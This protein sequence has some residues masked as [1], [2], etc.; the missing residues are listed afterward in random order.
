MKFRL[1]DQ[2]KVLHA[3]T[4]FCEDRI[5]IFG[6]SHTNRRKLWLRKTKGISSNSNI[7]LLKLLLNYFW[8]IFDVLSKFHQSAMNISGSCHIKFT[9]NW[10]KI[11]NLKFYF[12]YFIN[13]VSS[14]KFSSLL[15]YS[16]LHIS[17]YFH[18]NWTNI[19][20]TCHT[21]VPN[22]EFNNLEQNLQ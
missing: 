13:R 17:W 15:F 9:K 21:K 20:G 18:L 8:G 22:F 3:V 12:N 6:T 14:L 19:S 16:I 5:V 4:K 1:D 7:I 11:L 2:N 10:A